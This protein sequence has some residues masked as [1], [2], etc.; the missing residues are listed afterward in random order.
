MTVPLL[1]QLPLGLFAGLLLQYREAQRA[2]ANV[3]RGLGYYLPAK[4]AAGFAE[5]QA[6]PS[7]LKEQ[8]FAACMVT[9]AQR[10]TSLAEGM[11]PDRLSTLLDR[12]FETLFRVVERHGGLVTDVVGDGMTCVWTAA[13]PEAG[14][15]ACLAALEIDRELAAFNLR[16][17][18]LALPTRIGLNAGE[19]MVG[20]VGGGGRFAYSVVGDPVN[21]ASRIEELNR[22]L[23]TRILASEIVVSELAELRLRPLGRFLPVGKT[24][25]LRLA[26][27][28]GRKDGPHDA[29]LLD[30]FA[31]GLARFEA[32]CWNEAAA[33]F[34]AILATYPQDGP[35]RFYLE[36]CRRYQAGA[37]VPSDPGLIRLEHK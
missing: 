16:F 12:Y 32:G 14:R 33:C 8:L 25:P 36:R 13:P 7:A 5:G 26:E 24:K 37:P 27:V 11:T 19:V 30:A 3:S 29:R 21:T 15:R 31:A 17:E 18:P 28:L 9:D 4:I 6:D 1:V 23:G 35:T 22:Q 34:V 2:R 10:F 20:N